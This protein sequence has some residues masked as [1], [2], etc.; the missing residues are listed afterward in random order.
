MNY[1]DLYDQAVQPGSDRDQGQHELALNETAKSI[2]DPLAAALEDL[3]G[4]K[5]NF[6]FLTM[7]LAF[8]AIYQIAPGR[9]EAPGQLTQL[10]SFASYKGL[11]AVCPGDDTHALL[12]SLMESPEPENVAKDLL[13]ELSAEPAQGNKKTPSAV[14]DNK[15]AA[16][17]GICF[18]VSFVERCLF[19][20]RLPGRLRFVRGRD[21][22]PAKLDGA[23]RLELLKRVISHFPLDRKLRSAVTYLVLAMPTFMLEGFEAHRAAAEKAASNLK[24]L[25][26]GTEFQR[27]PVVAMLIAAMKTAGK[28]V[29]GIQHG[30]GYKQTDPNWWERAERYLCDTYR[31]WGYQFD[32]EEKPLP[33]IKLSRQAIKAKGSGGKSSYTGLELRIL[34]A[35]PYISEELECSLYSPPYQLQVAAI[36]SSLAILGPLLERDCKLTIRLHP[37]NKGA[38][39][40][41][42]LS[43]AGHPNVQISTGTRGSIAEDA[44][45]YTALFFSSP[46]ATGISE[47]LA[48]GVQFFVAASPDYFWIR[49]EAAAQYQEM[50]RCGIWLTR[51]DEV[52]ELMQ[53]GFAPMDHR[54]QVFRHSFSN[55]FACH[56]KDYFDQWLG[57]FRSV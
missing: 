56:S 18:G 32:V 57:M 2:S 19:K 43:V 36:E 28:P 33:S 30:G 24:A 16:K 7:P 35:V 6:S 22:Q 8:L 1:F 42:T 15:N 29:T 21:L 23:V 49:E 48:S 51:F 50:N 39:F 52:E 40:V 3:L 12:V 27:K 5:I 9:L 45:N 10:K 46:Q 55:T 31:S 20:A 26:I 17:V 54:Q 38:A 14:A 4:P 34:L 37:K 47:C 44:A 13:E 41:E 25:V 53:G 11:A